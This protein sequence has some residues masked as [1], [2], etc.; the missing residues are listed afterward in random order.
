MKRTSI[1]RNSYGRTLI[2]EQHETLKS[3]KK[4]PVK[5]YLKTLALVLALCTAALFLK[6]I[7]YRVIVEYNKSV[8]FIQKHNVASV[9]P[10][11]V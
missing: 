6:Q 10:L 11:G 3:N 9:S 4:E 8:A 5:N 1:K 7:Q 2:N